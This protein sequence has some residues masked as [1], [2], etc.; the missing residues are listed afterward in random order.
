MPEITVL[1]KI[2]INTHIAISG[3]RWSKLNP[4]HQ[5]IRMESRQI[6]TTIVIATMAGFILRKGSSSASDFKKF[7]LDNLHTAVEPFTVQ[8]DCYEV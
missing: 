7:I 8:L 6:N 4:V 5:P 2:V 3:L 1:V